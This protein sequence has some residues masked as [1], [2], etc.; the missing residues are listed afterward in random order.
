MKNGLCL[1]TGMTPQIITETIWALAC[2]SENDS[3]WIPDEVQVLSTQTGINQIKKRLL[4]DGVFA[5][6]Q[7]DYPQLAHI[8]FHETSLAVILHQSGQLSDLKTPED[9]EDAANIICKIIRDLTSQADVSL[10]V[11]IAGGRKTMGFYAGYALSLYG[12]AQD[13]MSHVLVEE[14]F[15]KAL[16]FFYPTPY[17]Y[18]V[19]DRDEKVIGDAKDA[20]VWLANIPFV[21]MKYAIKD[22]HQ[23][24]TNESFSNTVQKINES[25]NDVTLTLD[26]EQQKIIVN[27]KILI[28][29]VAPRE[30]ALLHWFA[31][32]RK[33]GGDGILPS[34]HVIAK[35]KLPNDEV[36]WNEIQDLSKA[37]NHYYAVLKIRDVFDEDNFEQRLVDKIFFETVK[38]RLKSFLEE[39]L[40]LELANKIGIKQNNG[41]RGTPFYLDLPADN[42]TII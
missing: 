11:S 1:V 8:K 5:Q 20:K 12:R 3:P 23:L 35:I 42:V 21:R 29:D 33:Q 18:L 22:K 16:S 27:D 39:Q 41:K 19:A 32:N 30:F 7:Q 34:K 24:N 4:T 9:N 15:E 10:H 2:D 37:Y 36:A 13:R 28:D 38:S 31:D 14:D 26:P 40:G 25:F 17:S 6:L